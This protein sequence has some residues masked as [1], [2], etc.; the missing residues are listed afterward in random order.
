MSRIGRQ[1]IQIPSGVTVEVSPGGNVK[2]TGPLG[3][4]EQRVPARM[5]VAQDDGAVTVT[6]PTDRGEGL[7]DLGRLLALVALEALGEVERARA[8]EGL[9]GE[10]VDELGLDPP[11]RPE[12]DQ[13]GTLR[14]PRDALADAAMPADARFSDG[15]RGHYARLPTFRRTYS[16]W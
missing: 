12:D 11:G 13:P 2:V 14:G 5:Q 4:L 1:P 15:K 3:T 10:I 8:G 9:A 7:P 6:R 16:P